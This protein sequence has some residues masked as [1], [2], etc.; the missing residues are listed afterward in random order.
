MMFISNWINNCWLWWIRAWAAE[1]TPGTGDTWPDRLNK[2][3]RSAIS[4]YSRQPPQSVN[5]LTTSGSLTCV[6]LSFYPGYC[7]AQRPSL[8]CVLLM[9]RP[10]QTWAIVRGAF[11]QSSFVFP[12]LRPAPDTGTQVHCWRQQNFC[13]ISICL[14]SAQATAGA[15]GNMGVG[16]MWR[17]EWCRGAWQ[18]VS[19]CKINEQILGT[20]D[21]TNRGWKQEYLN[22]K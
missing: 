12:S 20:T 16:D 3:S 11:L 4:R 9:W 19:N 5:I 8:C 22:T 15:G 7:A 18:H 2:Y 1:Q 14:N 17:E 21:L 10:A 13:K 6:I